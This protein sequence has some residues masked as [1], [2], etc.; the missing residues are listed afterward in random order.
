MISEGPFVLV[1]LTQHRL[2]R[3]IIRY[4]NKHAQ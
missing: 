3:Q 2:N 4:M 1:A